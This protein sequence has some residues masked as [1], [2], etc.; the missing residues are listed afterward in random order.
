MGLHGE[1]CMINLIVFDLD[2]TL[3]KQGSGI[4]W[5]DITKLKK[6]EEMGIRIA[7]CSGKPVSY[8][9]GFMRQVGLKAPILLGEN[10]A[11]FQ[12]G[13]E[14]PPKEQ[15]ILPYS[16]TAKKSL[17]TVKQKIDS[18]IPNIWYQPNLVGVTPFPKSDAEFT[19]IEEIL[20]E[21]NI[22]Q[23]VKIYRH[24]DCFDIVPEGIDKKEGVHVLAQYMGLTTKE[25]VAVGDGINDYP[26]FEFAGMALGIQ[27]KDEKLVDRNFDGIT[28]ALDFLI[29]FV[30]KNE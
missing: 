3:A 6:I 11:V 19:I 20:S 14:L 29:E 17:A 26:M 27:V 22:L 10:G 23:D 28:D 16:N 1:R 24:V 18:K 7:I 21:K 25:I 12:V 15:Y 2:G 4:V 30:G 8:L 9:C 5:S 13:I